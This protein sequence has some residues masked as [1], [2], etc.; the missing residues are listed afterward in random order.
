MKISWLHI[1]YR[2]CLL[3]RFSFNAETSNCIAAEGSSIRKAFLRGADLPAPFAPLNPNSRL[4]NIK[5]TINLM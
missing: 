2:F 4:A 5:Q 3:T 1:S